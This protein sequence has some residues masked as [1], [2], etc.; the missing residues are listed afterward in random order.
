MVSVWTCVQCKRDQS[1]GVVD[2]CERGSVELW[3][4]LSLVAA[5]RSSVPFGVMLV[6]CLEDEYCA[7]PRRRTQAGVME[8]TST[9][10]DPC[11][12]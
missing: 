2:Q 3:S 11:V 7:L 9:P 12:L 1:V 10:E 4:D 8:T 6:D 5:V